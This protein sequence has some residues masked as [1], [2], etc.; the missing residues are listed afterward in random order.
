M[1]TKTG[2]QLKTVL[3][4]KIRRSAGTR[5]RPLPQ[6]WD[7]GRQGLKVEAGLSWSPL[8]S[9]IECLGLIASSCLQ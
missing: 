5:A 3:M 2:P 9:L 6:Q 7:T 1:T 4:G 8:P